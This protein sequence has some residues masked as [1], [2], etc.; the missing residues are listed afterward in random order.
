MLVKKVQST[1]VSQLQQ[2]HVVLTENIIFV[3][4]FFKLVDALMPKCQYG[5][6]HPLQ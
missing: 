4:L 1:V 6:L 3:I 2:M 5:Y